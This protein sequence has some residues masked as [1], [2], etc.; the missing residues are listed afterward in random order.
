MP[1]PLLEFYAST[2]PERIGLILK[3]GSI[4]ELENVANEPDR[5]F[6]FKADD[7][8]RYEGSAWGS[9]HTHP[10]KSSNL[11]GLDYEGFKSWSS[12]KH[13]IIGNDGVACYIVTPNGEVMVNETQDLPPRQA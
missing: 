7:L 8:L 10:N 12:L 3:D 6:L 1:H 11:S 2:G 9:F 13:F 4:V 5:A